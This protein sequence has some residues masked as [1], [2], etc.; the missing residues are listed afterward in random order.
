[1]NHDNKN[2]FVID[3]DNVWQWLDFSSKF[4]A[5]RLI[6]KLFIIDKDYI[7]LTLPT[8]KVSN[9]DLPLNFASPA[10]EAKKGNRGGHNKDIIMLTINTFKKF[11]LKAG[12]KKAEEIHEYYIKLE[13]TLHEII[14]E[15][16]NEL[17]LQLEDKN[18]QLIKLDEKQQEQLKKQKIM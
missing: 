15:E 14:E 2:D 11:C 10:G 7:N 4:N 16:G 8:C 13:E 18:N 9:N 17:R 3:L 12:T 5:K 6:E 1:L